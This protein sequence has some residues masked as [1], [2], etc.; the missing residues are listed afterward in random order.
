MP[1]SFDQFVNNMNNEK[2]P[3]W[4]VNLYDKANPTGRNNK[5]KVRAKTEQE[6]RY[7]VE[8]HLYGGIYGVKDIRKL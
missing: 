1:I 7:I 3:E 5:I 6:A 4:S 2:V 8:N